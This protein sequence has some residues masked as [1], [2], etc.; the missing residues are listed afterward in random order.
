M[1]EIKEGE[2]PV[3]EDNREF[4]KHEETAIISLAFDQ[5][6]FFS[7]VLPHLKI[8]H[9]EQYETQYIF[10]IIQYHFEKHNIIVTRKL[11]IDIAEQ[12]LTADDPHDEILNLIRRESDPREV[13]VITDRLI[14]WARRK[15]FSLLYSKD[16]LEAHERGDYDYQ[17]RVIEDAR[18][19]N[20]FGTDVFWMFK[21]YEE[22]FVKDDSERFT[23][24][25]ESLDRCLNDGGPT[26]KDVLC[27]MAPT[28]VGKSIALPNVG[29]ANIRRKKNVLHVTCE[30]TKI[31]TA[32]RYLGCFTELVIK[33]RFESKEMMIRRLRSA[34]ASYGSEL[35]IAHY[36]PDEVSVDTIHGLIDTLK[37][38]HGMRVDTLII[39]YLELLIPRNRI[40][41][42]NEYY[43]QK[44]V[45][46]D[47]F[48]LAAKEDIFVA[49][50]SQSNRAG[51]DP[52][53]DKP[54][55][56]NQS[57]E[58]FGKNMPLS[59][60]VTI[61]QTKQE[62][63]EGREGDQVTNAKCRL[64]IAKNRNGEKFKTI[65]SSIN[66]QTM[67]MKEHGFL[68]STNRK[69]ARSKVSDKDGSKAKT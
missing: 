54:L 21:D 60:V 52:N 31:Q 27:F 47:I 63:E 32:L 2:L 67:I 41:E 49:T 5:P 40:R 65:S 59:Y 24:G 64:Y 17:E 45:S 28:G 25:F 8:D 33:K 7:A 48:N 6:E 61:N 3:V 53:A 36:P 35:A 38:V 50:A 55:D 14:E 68:E 26:R 13:P 37:R 9:F 4:G 22:L 23:T 30:M 56:L 20:N 66:Y 12:N 1:I 62:Y 46:T 34:S 69:V 42:E 57:A 58:S 15:Q 10:N 19:I 29:V 11:C 16:A 39:D 44:K 43:R 51:N 18:K